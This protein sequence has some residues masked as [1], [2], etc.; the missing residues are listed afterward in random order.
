MPRRTDARLPLALPRFQWSTW[1]R[2]KLAALRAQPT[3]TGTAPSGWS[4]I[5]GCAPALRCIPCS[6][7]APCPCVPALA[8]I[9][10]VL[11]L[12]EAC[13]EALDLVEPRQKRCA[14]ACFAR[15]IPCGHGRWTPPRW[16]TAVRGR[17]SSRRERQRITLDNTCLTFSA[18]A[19]RAASV[20][21]RK[22]PKE[23][24]F[25]SHQETESHRQM[26]SKNRV[27]AAV[28]SCQRR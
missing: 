15:W 8:E 28:G 5:S 14:C 13:T 23:A 7:H 22:I 25:A 18:W 11:V 9:Y 26:K 24:A 6:A 17:S 12:S 27:R 3:P 1:P 2:R 10:K 20:L 4:G 21:A 19:S 16:T